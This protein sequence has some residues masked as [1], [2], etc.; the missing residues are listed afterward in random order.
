[1]NTLET[2]SSIFS[3][4]ILRIPDYQR[5]YSWEKEQLEDLWNDLSN[6]NFA[7]DNSFHFTGIITLN[8]PTENNLIKLEEEGFELNGNS[9]NFFEQNYQAFN[10][11]DGQQRLVTLLIL[12]SL[13]VSSLEDIS[14][15][16]KNKI[17]EKFISIQQ[18]ENIYYLF[19]Y[20]KDIP[21]HQYLIGK[22]FDDSTMNIT[23]PETV[24]TKNLEN[25]KLFFLSKIVNLD[26][27]K[28]HNLLKKVIN[29]LLFYVFEIEN[30]KLDMSLVFETLNYRGKKL[31]KLELFKNR[32]IFLVT[33]RYIN[34]Q[35]FELRD[36][37]IAT[38]QDI[39]EWLGKND[40]NKLPDD[41]FLRA[42]WIFYFEHDDR[43]EKDFQKFEEDLFNEKYAITNIQNNKLLNIPQIERFLS[44]MSKA[45]KYWFFINNP[46]F[47]TNDE[48]LHFSDEIRNTLLQINNSNIGRYMKI[49]CMPILFKHNLDNEE[50][51]SELLY[52]IERHN[53]STYLLFGKQADTNRVQIMR[54]INQFFRGSIS[55]DTLKN[56][57][58]NFTS[59]H[60]EFENLNN[61]IHN[62]R[63]RNMKFFDWKGI[64]YLLWNYEAELQNKKTN[65]IEE[66]S[67]FSVDLIFPDAF[68]FG[69][70]YPN[71]TRNRFGQNVDT[72]K[73][74][75]GNITLTRR[76]NRA[77]SYNQLRPLLQNGSYNDKEI[78]KFTDWT[79]TNILLRGLTILTF[80]ENRW[81]IRLGSEQEKRR[82]L[83][84]NLQIQMNE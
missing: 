79:D 24:Y 78:A 53:F 74:S 19:G 17:L 37:I 34:Q 13:L 18:G 51:T 32:L 72:L 54:L 3:N 70:Q 59:K 46:Y 47:A 48:Q 58:I 28:R 7:V 44:T 60:I 39:Y 11:V 68:G 38:W 62:N 66:I 45:I 50:E 2:L 80:I 52:L 49:L 14:Q 30:D 56:E 65:E 55:K 8:K 9:V 29:R 64:K 6:I 35:Q 33:K 4:K 31:S 21:S 82:L 36:K 83:V 73:Y 23:E 5:G 10:V 63:Q 27:I 76:T 25:T 43:T 15:N 57:I 20:E 41:E 1:M 42:F 69:V 40:K 16:D 67:N 81:K 77:L 12:I 71:V 22:I 26:T 84:E 61:H 75:L